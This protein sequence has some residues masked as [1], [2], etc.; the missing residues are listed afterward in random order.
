M[1]INIQTYVEFIKAHDWFHFSNLSVPSY[2]R[3]K[4]A[5]AGKHRTIAGPRPLYSARIP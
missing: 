5:F 3:N 4:A 2:A 1:N